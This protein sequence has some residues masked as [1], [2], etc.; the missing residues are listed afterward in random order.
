VFVSRPSVLKV[1]GF[2]A[3]CFNIQITHWRTGCAY[4]EVCMRFYF[5]PVLF[6]L[7]SGGAWAQESDEGS[8]LAN[9][10]PW[11]RQRLCTLIGGLSASVMKNRQNE[12]PMSEVIGRLQAFSAIAEPD[13]SG[14]SEE[15]MLA[16]IMAAYKQPAFTSPERQENAIA[17]F[18]NEVELQCFEGKLAPSP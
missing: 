17:A 16:M 8:A 5:F 14:I 9:D 13:N 1:A 12:M 10:D 15:L 6:V 4:E 7:A 3:T 2:N 18:R 11:V